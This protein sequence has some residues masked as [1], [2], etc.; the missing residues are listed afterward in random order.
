MAA[1]RVRNGKGWAYPSL[2]DVTYILLD[3]NSIDSPVATSAIEFEY[4]IADKN[5]PLF[6]NGKLNLRASNDW[7]VALSNFYMPNNFE[8]FPSIDKKTNLSAAFF[9]IQIHTVYIFNDEYYKRIITFPTRHFPHSNYTAETLLSALNQFIDDKI[10]SLGGDSNK[11]QKIVEGFRKS[12]ANFY[13]DIESNFIHFEAITP[14]K[15]TFEGIDKRPQHPFIKILRDNLKDGIL[16]HPLEKVEDFKILSMYIW[17][18]SYIID[19]LG[20]FDLNSLWDSKH[21]SG[22]TFHG[23]ILDKLIFSYEFGKLPGEKHPYVISKECFK[24]NRQNAVHVKTDLVATSHPN[25]YG[26]LAICTIPR[27]D[28]PNISFIPPKL[29][30][31]SLRGT[32]IERIRFRL[33]DERGH[34]LN[35]NGGHAEMTLLFSPTHLVT[36]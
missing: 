11:G 21:L 17:T 7:S 31:R 8:T 28:E 26:N 9:S 18:G 22:V 2:D 3:I 35:Y 29:I 16:P 34:L 30:W 27:E 23:E 5:G 4:N 33:T 14:E 20:E 36:F 24:K 10:R 6:H 32:D 13:I 15:E 1:K 12:V 19:Y 25:G